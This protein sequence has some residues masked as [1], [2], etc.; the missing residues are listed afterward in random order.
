MGVAASGDSGLSPS[1]YEL[2]TP[3][4][5]Q[6][7]IDNDQEALLFA[8]LDEGFKIDGVHRIHFNCL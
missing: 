6:H 5:V 2:E 3:E 4:L 1:S 8:M 7:I